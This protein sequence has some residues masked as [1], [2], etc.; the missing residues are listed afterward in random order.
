MRPSPS[1]EEDLGNGEFMAACHLMPILGASGEDGW[2]NGR[3]YEGEWEIAR[4]GSGEAPLTCCNT[5]CPHLTL[6][7]GACQRLPRANASS[8][9][10]H[11]CNAGVLVGQSRNATRLSLLIP[12]LSPSP[13]P[14]S[15]LTAQPCRKVAKCLPRQQLGAEAVAGVAQRVVRPPLQPVRLPETP[16]RHQKPPR[17]HPAQGRHQSRS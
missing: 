16:C 15:Q 2:I 8:P 6:I 3:K 1:A 12:I 17:R 10:R 5:L 9:T 4:P 11:P 7:T 13:S 14:N